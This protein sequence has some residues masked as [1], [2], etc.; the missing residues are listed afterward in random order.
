MNSG[1][2]LITYT[3][4]ESNTLAHEKIKI[5]LAEY[6]FKSEKDQSTYLGG[7][8][9]SLTELLNRM[10]AIRQYLKQEEQITLYYVEESLIKSSR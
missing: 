1:K 5:L 3:L 9:V 10:V 2:F 7:N 4:R 8:N 6:G